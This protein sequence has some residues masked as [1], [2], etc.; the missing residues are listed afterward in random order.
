MRR[1]L[2]RKYRAYSFT[3]AVSVLLVMFFSLIPAFAASSG[4]IQLSCVYH[5]EKGNVPLAGDT[6][7][8]VMIADAAVD[9]SN[10]T[11]SYQTKADFMSY[12][13]NWH[14]CTSSQLQKKADELKQFV[15]ENSVPAQTKE[16]DA[17]GQALFDDLNPGLYLVFRSKTASG[18]KKYTDMP[19]LI[20]VPQ[21]TA[22]A[23]YYQVEAYPK[24]SVEGTTPDNP[25]HP[26]DNPNHPSE[27][28]LPNTG[29]LIWPIPILLS[30]GILM[31]GMGIAIN[32]RTEQEK[33][34]T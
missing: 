6:Y 2:R 14:D 31:L 16:T 27:P 25:F 21:V 20:T 9:L 17:E 13:C 11:V 1:N 32:K 7:S 15:T 26:Q 28:T 33:N 5:D 12:D 24:F 10:N 23:A 3:A 19:M 22:G 8:L 34:E 18:N 4:S 30:L 29:Q